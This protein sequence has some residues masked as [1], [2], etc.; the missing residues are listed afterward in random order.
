M[1]TLLMMGMLIG[2][3]VNLSGQSE[4]S[5][6]ASAAVT[7]LPDDILPDSLSRLPLVKREDLDEN[8]QRVFDLISGPHRTT[9]LSG[10]AALSLYSP[11]A[12]EPLEL[13]NRWLRA[14]GVLG[15]RLTELAILVAAR[16]L[17]QQYEWSGH[18]PAAVRAGVYPTVIDVIRF[19]K[20]YSGLDPRDAVIIRLGRQL[21]RQ[22]RV[23]SDIFAKAVELF[24]RQGTLELAALMGDYAM[25][26]IML[27]AIDQHLPPERQSTLPPVAGVGPQIGQPGQFTGSIARPAELPADVHPDSLC[28][29]PPIK[30]EDLDANGKRVWDIVVGRDTT[31]P[32]LGPVGISFYSPGIAEQMHYLN[33][34]LR[35]QSILGRR[36][37]ELTIIV[38]GREMNHQFEWAAHSPQAL[39]EGVDQ[40]IVDVIKYDKPLSGLGDKDATAIRFG[41]ELFRDKKVSSETFARAVQLFGRQGVVEMVGSMGNYYM[42]SLM[43]D[44]VGQQ[45]RPEWAPTL[46]VRKAAGGGHALHNPPPAGPDNTFLIEQANSHDNAQH[47]VQIR[48]STAQL[49]FK[50]IYSS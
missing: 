1:R 33:E 49:S 42:V 11:R 45:L 3:V 10:P 38:A 23:D 28:R 8:G 4:K 12:A 26:G 19:N 22:R 44:V 20:D 41:R 29:L 37:T 48:T 43:L 46:P 25:V 34:Y 47:A 15:P 7:K 2:I 36:M 40:S 32:Q 13:L 24:G 16:E 27:Q 14:N 31:T 30:R 21:F 5:A 6:S 18:E 50:A 35:K 9:R 39:R 17:D